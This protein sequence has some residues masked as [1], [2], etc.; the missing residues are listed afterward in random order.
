MALRMTGLMS[1]L[2]TESIVSALMKAQTMKKTKVDNKKTKLEW[3]QEA[4]SNVNTK[5]YNFYKGSLSKMRLQSAFLTK[6]ASSSNTTKLTATAS[7]TAANGTYAVKVNKLA[8]AQYVTSG[9]LGQTVDGKK[10]TSKTKLKDIDAGFTEGSQITI[11][12]TKSV[13]LN[14]DEN[15]TVN[16]FITTAQN[17]GLNATFDETQQR[18]FISAKK[19][20]EG[21]SFSITSSQMSQNQIDAMNDLM[22]AASYDSLSSSQ[23]TTVKNVLSNLQ[24]IPADADADAIQKAQDSAIK[25]L[26]GVSD[27][28]AKTT[29]TN[30]YKD[31]ITKKYENDNKLTKTGKL[32]KDNNPVLDDDGNQ[33]QVYAK[34]EDAKA[35][36]KASNSKITDEDIDK[37]SQEDFDAKIKALVTK[38]VNKEISSDEYKN[39]IADAVENGLKDA[40]GAFVKDDEG[41]TL[42]DTKLNRDSL[43]ESAVGV[44][45]TQI[46][47]GV[48]DAPAGSDP[49]NSLGLTSF[50]GADITEDA[51]EGDFAGSDMSIIAAKDSEIEFN[52]AK[53]TSSETTMTISGLTL[54]LLGATDG[55][56][57]N[58]NVT[59][60]TTA[61]YDAIKDF[62]NE[63]NSVLQMLNEKYNADSA[64][65]YDVL[66][67]EEKEAMT[68]D[69][70]EKWETK[71]KDSLLRRDTTLGGLVTSL[72][73]NMSGVFKASNGKTY[74]L[75]NLGITTSAKNYS[76]GGLLHIK[77]DEDDTEYVDETNKLMEMLEKDPDTVMEVITGLAGNLYTELGKK[78]QTSRLSSALTFY[79]DK[80]MNSQ[81]SDYKKQIKQWESKL[82]T[83]EERYYKQFT[84]MEKAMAS[85]NSQQSA[86]SSYFGG[87]Y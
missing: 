24:N 41:N 36:L 57:V 23:K 30:Y 18:F 65:G 77:G 6:A 19:S 55:E 5:L 62:L 32:D 9:K 34:T 60:D 39:K 71:I 17:A 48:S 85:M 86:L 64:R 56:T 76:E 61:V 83:L 74:S 2:D 69:E 43:I 72:R 8:A 75:A 82:A 78:M 4:W 40:G 59:K 3:K 81:L 46:S 58:I 79:N 29:V 16:D 14:I 42:V 38:E 25:S 7:S 13:T 68:D 10:V 52:G 12:G 20:G 22:A 47:S 80:E 63:Y 66:T 37:M 54:N 84:A 21:S 53:L 49:I 35:L 15:T 50:N 73:S 26:I 87:S 70:I 11:K 28:S 67:D 27:A 33:V 51:K 1:G 44:F 31:E 45:V